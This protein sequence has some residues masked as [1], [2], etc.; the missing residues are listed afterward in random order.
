MALKAIPYILG[1]DPSLPNFVPGERVP[2][3]FGTGYSKHNVRRK[4]G[5]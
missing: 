2:H 4:S 1:E 5:K 3:R